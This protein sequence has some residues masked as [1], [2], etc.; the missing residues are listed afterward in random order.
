M[1]KILPQKSHL[2]LLKSPVRDSADAFCR[3]WAD[4]LPAYKTTVKFVVQRNVADGYAAH[5]YG[6]LQAGD[7]IVALDG[8]PVGRVDDLHRLLRG[9]R[10]GRAVPCDGYGRAG[11]NGLS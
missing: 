5:G 7:V 1:P 10:A 3:R 2:L 11:S 8:V 9:D 6:G 4:T